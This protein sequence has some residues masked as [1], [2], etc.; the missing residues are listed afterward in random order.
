MKKSLIALIFASL[1]LVGCSD[2][3]SSSGVVVEPPEPE[4]QT[5][6]IGEATSLNIGSPVFD[7]VTG[8]LTFTLLTDDGLAITGLDAFG[9]RYVAFE[10]KEAWVHFQDKMGLANHE[11]HIFDCTADACD[12]TVT[13]GENGTYSLMPKSYSWKGEP[14]SVRAWLH[15]ATETVTKEPLWI[16]TTA[17]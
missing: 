17:L 8:E 11:A 7:D 2:D 14:D 4:P 1:A 5:V 6:A 12:V 9:L 16:D 13:A 15:I 3:D 10:D